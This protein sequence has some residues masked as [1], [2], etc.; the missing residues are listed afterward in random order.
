[1]PRNP[2]Q[3]LIQPQLHILPQ[4]AEGLGLIPATTSLPAPE[5][6]SAGFDLGA[7]D[8]VFG[9]DDARDDAIFVVETA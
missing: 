1:M 5:L 6:R 2:R 7:N 8:A 9:R 4:L 3:D